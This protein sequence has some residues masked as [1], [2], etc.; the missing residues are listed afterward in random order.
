[1]YKSFVELNVNF[2]RSIFILS[3]GVAVAQIVAVL[4][5]PIITRLVSVQEMGSYNVYLSYVAVFTSIAA[6]RL[7]LALNI[8]KNQ[9]IRQIIAQSALTVSVIV[10]MLL[11]IT[12]ILVF[13]SSA[14]EVLKI[15][16]LFIPLSILISS[17]HHTLTYV[18]ISTN[19]YAAV[20]ISN[21]IK[22]LSGNFLQLA[23][24][25]SGFN[26]IV[27]FVGHVLGLI[28]CSYYLF[29]NIKHGLRLGSLTKRKLKYT[30]IKYRNFTI[31]TSP[32]DLINNFSNQAIVIVGA[33]IFGMYEIGFI[34]LAIKLVSLPSSLLAGSISQS[35][36]KKGGD[37]QDNPQKLQKLTHE[38]LITLIGISVI[39]FLILA[40]FGRPIAIVIFGDIW[41]PVGI[42]ITAFCAFSFVNFAGSPISVLVSIKQ[43][44]KSLLIFTSILAL[45]RISVL[46]LS[47]L[48][49]V[50]A[51]TAVY[52]YVG[53]SCA[54]WWFWIYYLM[55]ISGKISY[56]ILLIL[57]LSFGLFTL[58][59]FIKT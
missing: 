49:S 3:S 52:L 27:L 50:N 28:L 34:G 7:E 26:G 23:L 5:L 51:L 44:Q 17:L 45:A 24:L 19:N 47:E 33:F 57:M 18:S 36:L 31:F 30:L 41:E 15:A 12:F 11:A 13:I 46:L 58:I 40:Y 39:P 25:F 16:Y 21:I 43:R 35:F 10:S 48:F 22:S 32:S 38:L 54:F 55:E 56:P 8:E 37:L 20:S 59:G 42:Y 2:I 29:F 6:G 14:I 9:R 4:S 1:M 53:V